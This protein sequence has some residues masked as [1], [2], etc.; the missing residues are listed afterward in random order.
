[1]NSDQTLQDSF[2]RF[3]NY[4]RIS[5]VEQCNLRCTYCMPE[6][7]LF[8]SKRKDLMSADEVFEIAKVFVEHGVN[9]IR[10][11]GGE[12][13]IR[14]DFKTI[15]YSLAELDTALS[16][17]SNA[18]L[19]HRFIDDFH[20]CNLRKIN[21]SLDTLNASK[22]KQITKRD[23]F[24]I[25]YNNILRL[26]REGFQVKINVVL[27]DGINDDEIL[28]FIYFTRENNVSIRFIEFMPFSG[29]NWDKSKVISYDEILNKTIDHFS[30]K[31]VVKLE[32]GDNFIS[33]N[34]KINSF[35]GSFGIISTI[36][37]P[38]CDGCNRIRLTAN[39]KVRNC[40]FS[41][42]E[43]DILS[44]HRDQKDIT[45]LIALAMQNKKRSTA[46]FNFMNDNNNIS[47]KQ[48]R[49]MTT[50]GG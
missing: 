17:T 39:G 36:T 37:N 32:D 25:V 15:L 5:L 26:I 11:T 21:L 42:S 14:E 24:E 31:E 23:R 9:K 18:V 3:H 22:F 47:S 48:N 50:I 8:L 43:I 4:L 13:L 33:R 34:F 16:I 46:G 29:N 49:S 12:P 28:D 38:F 30:K 41:K 7:G 6:E 20:L 27:M 35:K 1:M 19:I 10:L 44:A 45:P 2:G 40:L